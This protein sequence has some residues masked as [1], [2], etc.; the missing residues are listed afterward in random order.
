MWALGTFRDSAFIEVD[1]AGP[2]FQRSVPDPGV[3]SSYLASFVKGPVIGTDP[4]PSSIGILEVDVP[5]NEVWS[6]EVSFNVTRISINRFF[7]ALLVSGNTG[8]SETVVDFVALSNDPLTPDTETVTLSGN[9]YGPSF[10][11][12][13]A[14]RRAGISL[15]SFTSNKTYVQT[16]PPKTWILGEVDPT[17]M[18]DYGVPVLLD[19]DTDLPIANVSSFGVVDRDFVFSFRRADWDINYSL[20]T[21]DPRSPA[22]L[23]GL[24]V[25]GVRL[26]IPPGEIWNVTV[27]MNIAKKYS[28]RF[29]TAALLQ[30]DPTIL[31]TPD[32]VDFEVLL[33]EVGGAPS[34]TPVTLTGLCTSE[35]YLGFAADDRGDVIIWNFDSSGYYVSD[36]PEPTPTDPEFGLTWWEPGSKTYERGVDRGVLY[37]DDGRVV[38]WNG[39]TNVDEQFGVNSEPVYFDGVKLSEIPIVEGFSAKVS[40]ITYPDQLESAYGNLELRNGVYLGEQ[41]QNSFGF[42]YRNKLGTDLNEDAGY[43]IHLVY[44]ITALPDSRS[45]ASISDDPNLTEFSW[46]FTTTPEAL[47]GYV[48]SAHIVLDTT[49]ITPALL[50]EIENILYGTEAIPPRLPPLSELIDLITEFNNFL[51]ITDNGDGTWTAETAATGIINDLG[52]GVYEIQEATIQSTG[53][54]SYLISSTPDP[55]TP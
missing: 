14:D 49:E 38:P 53:P 55:P 13:I 5:E 3:P 16:N 50:A 30:G 27:C 39:L 52:G 12:F 9:C 36:I 41:A 20:E 10:V 26:D 28:D 21:P 15:D 2:V 42:S 31:P 43:K 1:D 17:L 11:V 22:E 25:V 33:P 4:F 19:P 48:A 44:N 32:L 35:T 7:Q 8:E 37:F 54:T 51:T 46:E 47:A 29:V 40:A 18:S 45:Y 24:A 6:V 34:Q 23:S